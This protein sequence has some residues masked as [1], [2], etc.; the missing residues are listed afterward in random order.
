MK[1]VVGEIRKDSELGDGDG[2]ERSEARD[3]FLGGQ[4]DLDAPLHPGILLHLQGVTS[5]LR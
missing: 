2:E 5:K 3:D 4:G 1:T